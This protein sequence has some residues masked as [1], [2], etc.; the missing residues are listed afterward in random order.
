MSGQKKGLMLI[1]ILMLTALIVM[2]TTSM[3][4]MSSETLVLTGNRINMSKVF[5]AAEAGVEYAFYQLNL[6]STWTPTLFNPESLGNEYTFEFISAT[7][8]LLS[9]TNN[10][11]TPAYCYELLCKGSYKE[12]TGTMRALFAREDFFPHPVISEGQ[13]ILNPETEMFIGDQFNPGRVH[14]N[15][16]FF[17]YS[18]EVVPGYYANVDL[19][20]GFISSVGTANTSP[21]YNPAMKFKDINDQVVPVRVPDINVSEM[22]DNRPAGCKVIS[23]HTFYIV[24]YFEYDPNA[25]VPYCI[26]HKIG[27]AHV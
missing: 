25:P 18:T 7:N 22:V 13:I 8:N 23:G 21:H 24:G 16:D 9:S 10:G 27:R 4:F 3:I 19:N 5:H 20:D 14:S 1:T 15:N 2:L 17:G 26:P 11:T 12:Y 6:D